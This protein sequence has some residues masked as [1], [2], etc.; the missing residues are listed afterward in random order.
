MVLLD[1]RELVEDLLA[2]GPVFDGLAVGSGVDRDDMAGG[3]PAV[4][5]VA[6]ARRLRRL[7]TVVIEATLGDVL[8]QAAAVDAARGTTPP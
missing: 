1:L 5:L 4:V 7:A 2:E 3:V 8:P 6:E